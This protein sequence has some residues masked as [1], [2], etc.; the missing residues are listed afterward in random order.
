MKLRFIFLCVF[1]MS[2]AT[3]AEAQHLAWAKG[4]GGIDSD[5]GYSIA[6]DANG[7]TYII[8]RFSA[9]ADFDPG[10]EVFNLSPYGMFD[11]FILKL[12]A[13]GHL[14]WAKQMGGSGN[15][16][17]TSITLDESG[18]IYATG[19]FEGTADFDPGPGNLYLNASGWCDV[20]VSKLDADGNLIWAKQLGGA[21]LDEVNS[22]AVSS[23][24]EVYTMGYFSSTADFDPGAGTFNLVSAGAYDIYVSK[25]DANGD[26][27]WAKQMG[28][29]SYDIGSAV[30]LDATGNVYTTGYF[31]E[32]V[33]VDPG[34]GVFTLSAAGNT[35]IYIS[36]LDPDGNFVWAKQ[37]G[38]LSRDNALTIALDKGGNIYTA[39]RFSGTADFDPGDG[40]F[41]LTAV[42][43]S[44]IFVSKL[45]A[46]GDF[47][48]AGQI[49]GGNSDEV[50]SLVTDDEE[51]VY[52][53][54][55]FMETADFD[56]GEGIYNLTSAGGYSCFV[57]KLDISGELVW[58]RHMGGTEYDYGMSLALDQNGTVYVTGVFQDTADFNPDFGGYELI[59]AGSSDVFVQKILQCTHTSSTISVTV[60]DSYT[61][62]S[63][64]YTWTTSGTYLDTISNYA[65]CDSVITINLTVNRVS[66]VSTTVSEAT[67]TASNSQATYQWLD[68]DNDYAEIPGET[69]QVFTPASN[70]SYAVELTENG[71]VDTSACTNITTVGILENHFDQLVSVYPN[72]TAGKLHIVFEQEPTDLQ[73]VIYNLSGEVVY[74][75]YPGSA[76]QVD[77]LL[78]GRPGVYFVE[79]SAKGGK[80]VFKV[81]K[82]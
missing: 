41:N 19:T 80:A 76:R 25:L 47:I 57:F 28:G 52:A 12:D 49:G 81:I 58:A 51:N 75:E 67:I 63:S 10:T 38:G 36:K 33:D 22:V 71:C 46:G 6:V 48:W 42:A 60:C 64:K 15:D 55:L 30:V 21:D 3:F 70:G 18:N 62:P 11:I 2:L 39:G 9:T 13:D 72:P 23:N 54:G 17:G 32:T 26:F 14:I 74:Q 16:Y 1:I 78:D 44:D 68:C 4:M 61:S 77:L 50:Y 31:Q 27:L 24:G 53:T 37:L 65:G 66:D 34:T 40:V 29:T 7:N 73:L 45:D 35:D 8:G 82:E 79:I 69:E 59:S 56:P 20:F 5:H 43:G